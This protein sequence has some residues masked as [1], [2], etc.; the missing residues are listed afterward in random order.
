MASDA[1]GIE[2]RLSGGIGSVAAAPWR[3]EIP[4]PYSIAER[5][6]DGIVHALGIVLA[7]VG[8]A[9]FLLAKPNLSP[10]QL[11]AASIYLGTLLVSIATSAAYNMW[12]ISRIKWVLRR[13]DHSAIYL[14]IAGTYTPFLAMLGMKALLGVVWA[15]ALLGI[16]LKVIR[17][18]EYDR[19]SIVLYLALGWSGALV[20]DKLLVALPPSVLSLIGAGGLMYSLGVIFHVWESLKFQNAIWHG[21]VLTAA[22]IHYAAVWT[23]VS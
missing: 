11:A 3:G 22:C 9:V 18:G 5:W 23:A 21:F 17:P 13:L 6:A 7:L 8:A 1:E 16:L 20:F 12:P 19:L 15:V 14:L 10:G 2:A 4:W